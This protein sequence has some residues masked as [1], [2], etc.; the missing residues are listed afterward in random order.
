MKTIN[1]QMENKV[2]EDECSEFNA[3]DWNEIFDNLD[4]KDGTPDGQIDKV[5]FLEWIDT[6]SFQDSVML[7]A[8]NGIERQY[9][10]NLNLFDE[11]LNHSGINCVLY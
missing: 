1:F 9:Q 5:A 8:N 7:E 4:K 10:E 11:F 3:E 6:L 2:E